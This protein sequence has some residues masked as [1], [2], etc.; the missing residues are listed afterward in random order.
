M[1]EN[2][3]LQRVVE[4]RMKLKARFEDAQKRSPSMSDDKPQGEGPPNRHGMPQIPTGQIKT[5]KWPVLD[6]GVRP[7][8]T[9]TEAWRVVVDGA[10]KHP[11]EL[12]WPA[13]MKL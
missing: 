2:E 7:K 1:D 10:V 12:D 6:L 5:E 8:V 3:K 13:L 11:I 4:A 9:T